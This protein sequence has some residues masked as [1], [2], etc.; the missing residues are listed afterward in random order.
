MNQKKNKKKN[1]TKNMDGWDEKVSI[2][3]MGTI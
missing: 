2:L 3:L 1:K